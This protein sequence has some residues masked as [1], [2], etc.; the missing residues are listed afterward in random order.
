MRLAVDRARARGRRRPRRGLPAGRWPWCR[1]W[2]RCTTGT[3]TL[4]A[5][6][7]CRAR[8]RRRRR[9]DLREP[10]AVRRRRGP[11]PLPAH[12]S[13]PTS[14]CAAGPGADLVF[15]PSVDE[16]YPARRAAG[17]AS[18]PG[19]SGGV[20]E[21]A[22]AAR[23]LRRRAHRG[24]QAARPDPAR[25]SR[26][27]ARRTTSSSCWSG[28]WSRDLDLPVVV[29]AVP[30]VR[31]RR[32]PGPVAAATATSTAADGRPP[33]RCRGRCA[34]GAGGRPR[35]AR[36]RWSRPPVPCCRRSRR[37]GGRLRGAGRPAT[38]ERGPRHGGRG[39]HCCSW[40]PGSGGTR[41]I[42]N[43]ASQTSRRSDRPALRRHPER[44]YRCP[45]ACSPRTRAGG[46]GRTSSSSAP[47][48]PGSPSALHA[49]AAGYR[50]L[51]VTKAQVDEGSTR[52]AQGGHR[53]GARRGR[54]PGASTCTT[55]SSPVSACATRTRS[56]SLVTEGPGAVRAADRA[57]RRLRPR[58]RRAHRR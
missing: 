6:R 57:R 24:G 4:R 18:A 1:R 31:E 35:A 58:R 34:A 17:H 21:G 49:R 26:S 53:R 13:T 15:A 22:V 38:F 52:W 19:R 10:A 30:T 56:A 42:D 20:L 9:D 2:A 33:R 48:S 43:C 29:E 16:M 55:R 54:H 3:A 37:R 28:A 47:A 39:A 12:A 45:R 36:T 11:R 7:R 23:S 40:P 46:R 14:R 41:L 27:S 51:L 25:T 5:A 32:R 8:R 50:V 44:R